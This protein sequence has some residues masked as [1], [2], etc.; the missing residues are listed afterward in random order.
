[1]KPAGYSPEGVL[2]GCFGLMAAV[3]V[4]ILLDV[5]QAHYRETCGNADDVLS[6]G[7]DPRL[8]ALLPA[9][10]RTRA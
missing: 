3:E 6:P 7:T 2:D 4:E 1:M 5:A 9:S 8:E 10:W